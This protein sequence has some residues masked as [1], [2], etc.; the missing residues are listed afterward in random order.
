VQKHRL[1]RTVFNG[2]RVAAYRRTMTKLML[3]GMLSSCACAP[4]TSDVCYLSDLVTCAA[5]RWGLPSHPG[6]VSRRLSSPAQ[7]FGQRRA[8]A[9]HVCH[10]GH[11]RT[12]NRGGIGGVGGLGSQRAWRAAGPDMAERHAEVASA[13][14]RQSN[15]RRRERGNKT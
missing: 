4:P 6:L 8:V 12:G 5:T 10:R 14:R 3:A 2:A 15:R 11:G 7:R 1:R 13:S 9:P